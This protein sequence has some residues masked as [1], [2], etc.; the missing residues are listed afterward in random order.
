MYN[1]NNFSTRISLIGIV[2]MTIK[3]QMTK[4]NWKDDAHTCTRL[5]LQS[6]ME[7]WIE[8]WKK[9]ER[10]VGQTD[11]KANKVIEQW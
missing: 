11:W 8:G 1:Y 2:L 3:L 4:E 6:D 9:Q 10:G 5:T 7:N